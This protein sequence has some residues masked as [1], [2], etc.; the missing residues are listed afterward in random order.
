ML[1]HYHFARAHI[2]KGGDDLR[3]SLR[4]LIVALGVSAL[5]VA[6]PG[7]PQ[8]ANADQPTYDINTLAGKVASV[9]GTAGLQ[10]RFSALIEQ[11]AEQE[12]AA[13]AAST[14]TPAHRRG[15]A[16]RDGHRGRS[17]QSEPH[18]RRGQ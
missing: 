2:C 14:I 11:E 7:T 16:E 17:E 5:I 3:Y 10:I 8:S 13:T 18:R 6:F 4:N 1:R 15:I 12:D 9:N